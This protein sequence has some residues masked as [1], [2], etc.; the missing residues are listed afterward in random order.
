MG[1]G[2]SEALKIKIFWGS[3]P[4][5]PL[6]ARAFGARFPFASCAYLDRKTTLRPCFPPRRPKCIQLFNK[7]VLM[8]AF[9]ELKPIS[10]RS[11]RMSLLS[12]VTLDASFGLFPFPSRL[13]CFDLSASLVLAKFCP[14]I[15]D[16]L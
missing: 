11:K 8:R 16:S 10:F 1:N 2:I 13:K 3:M 7:S 6:A 5:Y 12:R 15:T 14:V 9:G 4:P